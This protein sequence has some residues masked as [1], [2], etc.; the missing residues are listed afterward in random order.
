VI[1]LTGLI[2]AIQRASSGGPFY[3]LIGAVRPLVFGASVLAMATAL[4]LRSLVWYRLLTSTGLPVT[5]IAAVRSR[6]L[7]VFAKY[8]PGKVWTHFATSANL[9]AYMPTVRAGM[10]LGFAFQMTVVGGGLLVGS[11][12]MLW[13]GLPVMPTKAALVVGVGLLLVVVVLGGV[14]RV[15]DSAWRLLERLAGAG[16]GLSQ[17][18]L[19]E[20]TA[21]N[22]LTWLIVGGAQWLMIRSFGLHMGWEPVFFQGVANVVGMLAVVVPAGIGVREAVMVSYLT[23]GGLEISAAMLIAAVARLWSILAEG[24]VFGVGV[25]LSAL[26]SSR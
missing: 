22:A 25:L 11:V 12:G 1:V 15:R 10:A 23:L 24:V 6:S 17:V 19:L 20:A 13:L 8:V 9:Q 26:P 2:Y 16:L 7:P 18:A 14:K 21:L 3:Q 5:A 4:L